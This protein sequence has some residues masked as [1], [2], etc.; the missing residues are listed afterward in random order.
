MGAP[1]RTERQWEAWGEFQEHPE[2]PCGWALSSPRPQEPGEKFGRESALRQGRPC[3]P[4]LCGEAGALPPGRPSPGPANAGLLRL[5]R[6]T[7]SNTGSQSPGL[8]CLERP[9]KWGGRNLAVAE[10]TGRA[11]LPEF[12]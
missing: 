2:L 1:A 4:A 3:A 8:P 5:Q 11:A 9:H 10:P 7:S 12:S 6:K